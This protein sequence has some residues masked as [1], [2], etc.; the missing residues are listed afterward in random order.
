MQSDQ[1]LV[2]ASLGGDGRAFGRLV[3]RYQ[4]RVLGIC[5]GYTRDF[6]AAEDAAQEALVSAFLG[7]ANLKDPR[8]FGPWL[9]QMAVNG[10]LMWIRRNRRQVPLDEADEADLA[11]PAPS[12]EARAAQSDAQ[13]EVLGAMGRLTE[14]QQQA[15]TLF[16]L[17]EM[18]I[19]EIARF[20]DVSE[21]AV[22]QR[23][24]R[25]R[26]CLKEEMLEMVKETLSNHRMPPDF[27]EHVVCE[28]LARGEKQLA[29]GA[30]ISAQEEFRKVTASIPDHVDAQ[31]GL[32]L[33]LE[34]ELRGRLRD[35][36]VTDDT[37]VRE[38]F[39]SLGKAYE[40]GA[41]DEALIR[42][43]ARLYSS[44]G[45]N[46]EGGQFLERVVTSRTDWR[47][48]IRYL[49]TAISV[50][51]HSHYREG[52]NTKADCV[53]CHRQARSLVP[54]DLGPR[55]KLNVWTP[56]G[57]ALAYPH[58]GLA[59]EVLSEMDDLEAAIGGEGSIWEYYQMALI[60]TNTFRELEQYGRMAEAART[61]VEKVAAWPEDDA[62]LLRP[63]V[64]LNESGVERKQTGPCARF[65]TWAFML[66]VFA[67]ARSEQGDSLIGVFEELDDVLAAH[68]LHVQDLHERADQPAIDEATRQLSHDY[69][70]AGESAAR[71]KCYGRALGYFDREEELAGRLEMHGPVYRAAALSALGRIGEAKQQL[72][73]ISGR[74]VTS[75]QWRT[76]FEQLDAF[77]P[78]RNDPDV[79]AII[80]TWRKTEAAGRE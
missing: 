21:Q 20:L 49:K 13:R 71:T 73:S 60:R 1:T 33:S 40:L 41:T 38:T 76:M 63:W 18:S 67:Q 14:P 23:L 65:H 55:L 53:R 72:A 7:L 37:L 66:G 42:R 57:M 47:E 45:R 79:L 24:Y 48:K 12:P 59:D 54:Q 22:N 11:S 50:Y 28:I 15:L 25:A 70:R 78:I 39:E 68:G 32:A 75:G 17:E 80:D 43:L 2:K 69:A 64:S 77:D 6:D 16:Y 58:Q 26:Q 34:G 36:S 52:E 19:R 44:F 4:Y 61:F 56:A 9:R 8:A 27:T 10:A 29:D 35:G 46:R 31:R 51:Y 5:L 62:R 74:L 3:K 30:W